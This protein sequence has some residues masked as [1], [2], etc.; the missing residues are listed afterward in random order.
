VRKLISSAGAGGVFGFENLGPSSERPVS[1][2]SPG[3]D[4][5]AVL[6]AICDQDRR[7][8]VVE[9]NSADMVNIL[10]ADGRARGHDVLEHRLPRFDLEADEWPQNLIRD[11]AGYSTDLHVYLS[12]VYFRTGG[13]DARKG[14]AGSILTG[15]AKPPHFSIHLENPTVRDI[16]NSISLQTYRAVGEVSTPVQKLVRPTSWEFDFSEPGD[17]SYLDWVTRLFRPLR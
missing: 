3:P 9:T 16:L 15:N 1:L 10:P 11:L 12:A 7:Y 6:R 8:R 13:H 17:Q 14:Q 4:V 2:L 5:G